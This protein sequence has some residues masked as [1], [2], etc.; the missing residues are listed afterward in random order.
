MY[1][2]PEAAAAS[3]EKQD[4]TQY[5]KCIGCAVEGVDNHLTDIYTVNGTNYC[6][7]H[8]AKV[9]GPIITTV[10]TFNQVADFDVPTDQAN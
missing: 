5:F 3:V 9:Y 4:K 10:N 1:G 6:L 2:V 7:R 8:G